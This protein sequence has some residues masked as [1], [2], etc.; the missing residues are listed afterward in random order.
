M[1][2]SNYMTQDDSAWILISNS[3]L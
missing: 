1:K 3:T 2:K